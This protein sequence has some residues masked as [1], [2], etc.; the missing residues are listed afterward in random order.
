MYAAVTATRLSDENFAARGE[1]RHVHFLL[2]LP[3]VSLFGPQPADRASVYRQQYEV[4]ATI[5]NR[6]ILYRRPYLP[7]FCTFLPT[8]R[9]L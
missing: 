3:V 5:K 6:L 2:L 1:N 8:Q 9:R 7:E 4:T